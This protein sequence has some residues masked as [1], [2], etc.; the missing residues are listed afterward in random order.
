MCEPISEHAK[1]RY[2][3]PRKWG[4]T[5]IE[6]LNYFLD[7]LENLGMLDKKIIIRPHPSEPQDKYDWLKEKRMEN[8]S[9]SDGKPLIHEITKCSSVVGCESMAMVVALELGKKVYSSIPPGGRE[10]VL[11]H[12]SI[13]KIK[14]ILEN[15]R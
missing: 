4:Y 11:P 3:N 5:E 8:I 7:N 14:Y 10:C 9:L 12:E 1:L 15:K 13:E 2:G 6:A